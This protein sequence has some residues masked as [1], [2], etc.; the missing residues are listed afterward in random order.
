[1]SGNRRASDPVRTQAH[2]AYNLAPIQRF[3]SLNNLHPLPPLPHHP[4]PESGSVSLQ[5][6]TSPEGSS[7]QPFTP[8]I[9][10]QAALEALAM[11]DS[12]E[13]GLLLGEE[14][15]LP[16]E[17]VQYLHSQVQA[18]GDYMTLEDQGQRD[19]Q[20]LGEAHSMGFPQHQ[21]TDRKSPSKLPIQWNEV[22]SGSAD[23]SPQRG[24]YPQCERW[25]STEHKA[26]GRFSN[27]VVQQQCPPDFQNPCA[28]SA[29]SV[30]QAVKTESS[31]HACMELRGPHNSTFGK[32]L[33]IPEGPRHNLKQ[34]CFS[35]AQRQAHQQQSLLHTPSCHFGSNLMLNRTMDNLSG[36]SQSSSLHPNRLTHVPRPPAHPNRSQS[37]RSQHYF[38]SE[39]PEELQRQQ[40]VLQQRRSTCPTHPQG[41]MVKVEAPDNGYLQQGFGELSFESGETKPSLFPVDQ[42]QSISE[43]AGQEALL[44]PASDQVTSTVDASAAGVLDEVVTLDLGV[45]LEDYDQGSLVSGI[46]SPSMFQGLTRTSSRLTTPHGS[47]AFPPVAPVAPG[48]NNMAIGDMSSLL[49]S[50]AEESKFL[51]I[52]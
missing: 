38:S 18:D 8:S 35:G 26:F 7:Q 33:Q 47:A 13:A 4:M 36:L 49:T 22:S 37:V 31:P 40:G 42:L 1:M 20:A 5:N 15:I 51:A 30:N 34:Q 41:S 24:P 32:F 16:D 9:A 3:N 25:G 17:L 2:D 39:R 29:C 11:E 45:M 19:L 52:M 23:L 6:Y 21:G 44:S 43:C 10:E 28:Q 27:M 48:L 14:C 12:G 46:L 50:L